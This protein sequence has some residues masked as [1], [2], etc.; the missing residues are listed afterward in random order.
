MSD[1]TP[2]VDTAEVTPTTV[3]EEAVR[4]AQQGRIV[5]ETLMWTLAASHL[6]VGTPD[7]PESDGRITG[8]YIVTNEQGLN[9]LPIF[10]RPELA[11]DFFA[12]SYAVVAEVAV[13]I[14]TLPPNTGIVLN[15]GQELGGEF[16]AESIKQL[17]GELRLPPR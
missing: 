8:T 12:N 16:S 3:V 15:P 1:S 11:Q 7:Q 10:T 5:I 9:F 14:A 4:A 17:K 2:Q 13:L 6:F